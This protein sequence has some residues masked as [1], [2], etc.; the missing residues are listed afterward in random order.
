MIEPFMKANA[1]WGDK[2]DSSKSYLNA[3]EANREVF[4]LNFLK[5]PIIRN[6]FLVSIVLGQKL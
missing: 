6:K 3:K 4:S 2:K 1:P 5:W